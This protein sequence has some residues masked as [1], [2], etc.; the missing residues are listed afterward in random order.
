M[1]VFDFNKYGTVHQEDTTP[2]PIV[3]GTVQPPVIGSIAAPV[4][5]FWQ[6]DT[7]GVRMFWDV[8][9]AKRRAAAV[10]VVVGVTW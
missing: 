8:G 2:L 6:T 5:S 9:W 3:G 4:R 10:A 7:T 1:P